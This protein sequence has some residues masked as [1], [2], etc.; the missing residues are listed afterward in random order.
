MVRAHALAH[1][2]TTIDADPTG[3]AGGLLAILGAG[4]A[5]LLPLPLLFLL[6]PVAAVTVGV[7][8]A[9]E[10]LSGRTERAPQWMQRSG[11]EWLHRLATEP[12]RLGPRYLVTNT[13]RLPYEAWSR[14]DCCHCGI[15]ELRVYPEGFEALISYNDTGHLP[16]GLITTA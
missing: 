16:A 13:L 5:K 10:F 3:T 1:E 8:A 15:T 14:F 12:R 11:L 9:F 7:G 4:V 2:H 6:L